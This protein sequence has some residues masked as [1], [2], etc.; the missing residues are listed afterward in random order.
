MLFRSLAIPP[1]EYSEARAEKLAAGFFNAAYGRRLIVIQVQPDGPEINR[2]AVFATEIDPFK[3]WRD[4]YDRMVNFTRP[5]AVA[6]LI[7]GG[8]VLQYRDRRGK[9]FRR[10][11][12]GSDPLMFWRDGIRC[13]VIGVRREGKE[14]LRGSAFHLLIK[15]D[16]PI[17]KQ[18][19]VRLTQEY[20]ARLQVPF[21]V[22]V[23]RADCWFADEWFYP[24][25]SG[26]GVPPSE[27]Q[28]RSRP[29]MRCIWLRGETTC[30]A[31]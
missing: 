23:F 28:Y 8:A 25:F 12:K 10:V 20:H 14:S 30:V 9:E 17:E 27:E 1:S 18:T 7:D 6:T 2:A 22:L 29:M 3:D 15:T 26:C 16:V 19:A 4:Q 5:E 24:I 21:L 11:L 31:R 13:E